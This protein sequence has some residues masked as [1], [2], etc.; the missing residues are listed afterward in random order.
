MLTYWQN[1]KLVFETSTEGERR[2]LGHLLKAIG[3][4]NLT[5]FNFRSPRCETIGDDQND[6]QLVGLDMDEVL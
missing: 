5:D 6:Q 1:N 2:V 3:G 4:L